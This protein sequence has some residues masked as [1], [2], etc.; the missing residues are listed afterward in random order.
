MNKVALITGGVHR[1][2]RHITLYLASKG[3]DLAVIYNSSSPTEIKRT[4]TL[5]NA[6]GI[7]YKLYKCDLKNIKQLKKIIDKIGSDFKKIDV[8]VNNSGVIKKVDFS[9]I[10]EKLFD[11]TIAV[12]L[13]APL[14]VSQFAVK[15]L[16]KA[17]APVIINIASL[18]GLQNW[19]GFMPYSLSKTGAVKLTYLLARRLAP[20]IRVNAIAPGTIIIDG[21]EKGTPSKIDVS[22]IPLKKYGTPADIINAV[23]FILECSYL[24]GHVIP[25]DGGR[26]LNN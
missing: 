9:D 21:E 8:L 4:Q 3:Y 5:L 23:E 18:G 16:N 12:N 14:F 13:K 20:K 1:L 2:G 26:I 6:F 19:T 11:D 22:K 10:T 25:I 15:Y 7:K 24:T 17:K